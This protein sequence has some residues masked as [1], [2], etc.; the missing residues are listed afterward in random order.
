[1]AMKEVKL[2]VYLPRTFV[3]PIW[4][5][6]HEIGAGVVGNYDHVVS[7]APVEGAWRAKENANPYA[8]TAGDLSYGNEY[9]L[10]IRC[11]YNQVK[12]AIKIIRELHP[13]EEPLINV[14]PLLNNLFLTEDEA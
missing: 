10:E 14:L 13:Y 8:G 11:P 3:E 2:E 5:A 1:M 7:F 6:L 12:K 4:E 9:K